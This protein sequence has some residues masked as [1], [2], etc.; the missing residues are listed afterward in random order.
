MQKLA[1]FHQEIFLFLFE[2]S[3]ISCSKHKGI[4]LNLRAT[5]ALNALQKLMKKDFFLAIDATT[6]SSNKE[7]NEN[8]M[9]FYLFK[10]LNEAT[11]GKCRQAQNQENKIKFYLKAQIAKNQSKDAQRQ[12]RKHQLLRLSKNHNTKSLF[13]YL[14]YQ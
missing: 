10:C 13:F 4:S 12:S 11:K 1:T 6:Q 8:E 5:Y 14:F 7:E 2:F 3:K 9:N